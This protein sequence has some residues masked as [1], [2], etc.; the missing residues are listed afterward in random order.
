MRVALGLLLAV[1]T[2]IPST[3]QTRPRGR[4]LGIPFPG[5]TGLN[6]AIT[7]VAGVAVGHVT[8]VEGEGRLVQ[9]KVLFARASPLFFPDRAATG[10]TC[11]P[12]R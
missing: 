12:R 8:L 3:A 10:I 5:R 6:N 2:V 1:V 4:D 7:D 9:V 11:L